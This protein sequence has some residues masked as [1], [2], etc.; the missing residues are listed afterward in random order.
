MWRAEEA[1]LV[2]MRGDGGDGSDGRGEGIVPAQRR[3]SPGL[4]AGGRAS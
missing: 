2:G 3:G 4:G 1:P